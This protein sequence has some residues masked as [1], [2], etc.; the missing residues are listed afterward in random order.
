MSSL[1]RGARRV[2]GSFEKTPSL[3]EKSEGTEGMCEFAY[4]KRGAVV[5]REVPVEHK[6]IDSVSMRLCAEHYED[7][8]AD[9]EAAI[10]PDEYSYASRARYRTPAAMMVMLTLLL[11]SF[12]SAYMVWEV[13]LVSV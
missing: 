11:V 9:A 4:C 8:F 13:L 7:V 10:D 2:S 5:E 3:P 12:F 6:T 1:D